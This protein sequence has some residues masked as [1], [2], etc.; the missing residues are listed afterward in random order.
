MSTIAGILNTSDEKINGTLIEE[1]LSRVSYRGIDAVQLDKDTNGNLFMGQSLLFTTPDAIYQDIEIK[2]QNER[3]LIAFDGRLDNREE[4]SQKLEILLSNKITDSEIII[5]SYLKWGKEFLSYL[6]GDFAF[7]LWDTTKKLLFLARDRIG[8]RNLYYSTNNNMLIWGSEIKQILQHPL[9]NREINE[10]YLCRFLVDEPITT[11]DTAYKRVNRLIPGQYLLVENNQITLKKYYKFQPKM[12]S[13]KFHQDYFDEFKELFL[14]SVKNNLRCIDSLAF[15]LSGGLDSSSIVSVSSYLNN[16]SNDKT[17]VKLKSYSYVFDEDDKADERE[18]IKSVL[19]QSPNFS[20]DFVKGDNLWD[21]KGNLQQIIGELDE[22]YPLFNQAFSRYIPSKIN[23]D[24]IKVHL[25]GAYGDHVLY[26]DLNYL[27]L[28]FK[29]FKFKKLSHE[30]KE[31][32]QN[33][34]NIHDLFFNRTLRP[35][36]KSN[37]LEKAEWIKE[38]EIGLN[39]SLI[40]SKQI[41]WDAKGTENHFNKIIYQSGIEWL[42]PYLSS[43]YAVEMRYPFLNHKLMEFLAG[44][45]VNLKFKPGQNKYILR[46]SLK[47]ILPEKIRTRKTKGAHMNLLFKGFKKE[48]GQ[49]EGY[50]EFPACIELGLIRKDKLDKIKELFYLYYMGMY[51]GPVFLSNLLRLLSLEIWL[52]AKMKV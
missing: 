9:I 22:P 5:Y 27:A 29:K 51:K 17:K 38:K 39:S 4:L 50:F 21:F 24:N 20:Y 32:L 10:S 8:I 34:F 49:I 37:S 45:P 42:S 41:Y 40:N 1:M 13:Y 3:Y 44:V 33:G 12:V 52:Q 25:T 31:W 23:Q 26:G 15:S 18:Y 43:I 6:E 28:L 30:Y 36:F 35:L 46:Q 7:S 47:G 48:W 19:D 14:R 2:V 11:Q 16:E